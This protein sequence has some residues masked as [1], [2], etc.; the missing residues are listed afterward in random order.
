LINSL[1]ASRGSSKKEGGDHLLHSSGSKSTLIT[2]IKTEKCISC[3]V[4]IM[5]KR[6]KEGGPEAKGKV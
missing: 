5:R 2:T 3:R 1:R 6:E 4:W